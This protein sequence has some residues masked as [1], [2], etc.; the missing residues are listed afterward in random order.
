MYHLVQWCLLSFLLSINHKDSVEKK[1]KRSKFF[2]SL[3]Q[4]FPSP[5]WWTIWHLRNKNYIEKKLVSIVVKKD[6]LKRYFTSYQNNQLNMK[7][8][9][10]FLPL[11]LWTILS[12]EHNGHQPQEPPTI[13]QE[14]QTRQLVII[15]RC[16]DFIFFSSYFSH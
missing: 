12:L 16:K 15:G 5:T 10:K 7:I 13:C 9:H 8:Y 14:W 11:S 4:F 2:L 1:N 3:S 6:I